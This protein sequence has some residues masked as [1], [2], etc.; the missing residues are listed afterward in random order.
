MVA[1]SFYYII[2]FYYFSSAL[3]LCLPAIILSLALTE[4]ISLSQHS[5]IPMPTSG[6]AQVTPL[7]YAKQVPYTRSL[8][9]PRFISNYVLFNFN[10]HEA[11]HQYPGLPCYCLPQVPIHSANAHSFWPWLK[12]VKQLKGVDFI[13]KTSPL[14]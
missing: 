2:I 11:H 1:L 3:L 4:I 9:F 8:L 14:P 5:N 7:P 13:F 6:G 12:K 10:Y